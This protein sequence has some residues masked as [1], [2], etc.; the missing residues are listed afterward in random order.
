LVGSSEPYDG[1]ILPWGSNPATDYLLSGGIMRLIHDGAGFSRTEKIA[2]IANDRTASRVLKGCWEGKEAHKNC[3]VCEKCIR[4]QA[5]F[6]AA[7]VAR[8]ACFDAPLDPRHIRLI[9]LRSA[10]Q[11][12]ELESIIAYAKA[13]GMKGEWLEALQVEVKIFKSRWRRQIRTAGRY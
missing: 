6:L 7:G 4:T 8:P 2:H 1:L 9:R 5:N 10:P 13:K 3:G 12:A 11:C